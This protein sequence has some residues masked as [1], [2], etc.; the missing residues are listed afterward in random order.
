MSPFL[1]V[2]TLFSSDDNFMVCLGMHYELVEGHFR[3]R[4]I[5]SPIT[6]V[7]FKPD[8]RGLSLPTSHLSCPVRAF[9]LPR[10][11]LRI[12]VQSIERLKWKKKKRISTSQEVTVTAV[13]QKTPRRTVLCFTFSA[14]EV[15]SAS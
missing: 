13:Y 1:T 8:D 11:A 7:L 14:T 3:L 12:P 5:F 9:T 10:C 2:F 15:S 4:R 6:S